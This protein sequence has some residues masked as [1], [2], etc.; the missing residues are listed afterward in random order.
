M[1][2]FSQY[3]TFVAVVESGTLSDAARQLNVSPSAI[4]KQ[5]TNLEE[6]TKVAL[7][8]RSHRNVKVTTSGRA[9]YQQCKAIL[10]SVAQAED[11]LLS[12]QEAVS[13]QLAITVSKSLL[14]SPL[15]DV[16]TAFS[17]HYP[18]IHFDINLSETVEDLHEQ[19]YDFAFRLGRVADSSRLISMALRDVRLLCCA[20]PRYLEQYGC[21]ASLADLH[22]HK[23]MVLSPENLSQQVRDFFR[24][25]KLDVN[26]N[27]FHTDFHT[28]ND[29]EAVYQAVRSGLCLGLMLDI[30]VQADI[31]QGDFVDVFP[32]IPLP[33]KKLCL[34]YKKGAQSSQKQ[35]VFKAFIKSRMKT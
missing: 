23:L 25:Q 32:S 13:G 9:F 28:T 30:A 15:F 12:E 4:S 31:E 7:F 5:L 10:Q 27:S 29:I 34:I 22:Q 33:S 3:R 14:R 26:E 1:G 11:A 18:S 6:A 20:S 24:K 17:D 19:G 2:K 21:P 16:L 35:K 8:E